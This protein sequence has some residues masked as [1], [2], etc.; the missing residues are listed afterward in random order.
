M[1]SGTH[2]NKP[3][4][5]HSPLMTRDAKSLRPD[6]KQNMN[7]NAFVEPNMP[8]LPIKH[9]YASSSKPLNKPNHQSVRGVPTSANTCI[10]SLTTALQWNAILLIVIF[11]LYL[12]TCCTGLQT[13]Y[14]SCQLPCFWDIL[15][16]YGLISLGIHAFLIST[17][18]VRPFAFR[19]KGPPTGIFYSLV[20]KFFG[21]MFGPLMKAATL[22]FTYV[23]VPFTSTFYQAVTKVVTDLLFLIIY[24][25]SST[26]N[27]LSEAI[28]TNTV[29]RFGGANF[30][31]DRGFVQHPVNQSS[32][33]TLPSGRDQPQPRPG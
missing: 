17:A 29:S 9:S 2:K 32:Q 21:A 1:S 14:L 16:K 11:S 13:R 10:T 33:V 7:C 31:Q 28:T 30:A 8:N 23:N 20:G 3:L 15:Y 25:C 19:N 5:T 18:A 4:R 26:K 22:L 6:Y 27:C 24:A 12:G